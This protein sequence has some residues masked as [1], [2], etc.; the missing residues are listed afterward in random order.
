[1]LAYLRAENDYADAQ[2]A[3]TEALQKTLYEEMVSRIAED[4]ESPPYRLGTYLYFSRVQKGAQYPVYLRKKAEAE[5]ASSAPEEVV[6]DLNELARG[7]TFVSVAA[8][9]IS[10]DETEIAYREDTAGFRQYVLHTRNLV[11]GKSS[12]LAIPRVDGVAFSADGKSLFYVTEDE[13]TKRSNKLFHHRLGTDPATDVL[14]YEEKDEMYI[15]HIERSRS[16]RWLFVTSASKTTSEVRLVELHA[17]D[18]RSPAA[19]PRLVAARR[20]N[21]E[22][23]CDDHESELYILTNDPGATSAW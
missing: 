4:D 14:L 5:G 19:A 16:K 6:L 18:P 20:P 15:L 13:Q 23:Y 22:Y 10:D 11:T 2:M 3:G 7:K 9:E 8:L 21:I 12:D 17:A 1:V